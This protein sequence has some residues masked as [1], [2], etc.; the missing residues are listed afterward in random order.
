MPDGTNAPTGRSR[1]IRVVVVD[2]SA[3]LRRVV[4]MCLT[5]EPGIEVVGEAGTGL[6]A[7]EL[8][9]RLQPDIVLL[10]LEMPEMDGLTALPQLRQCSPATRIAVLSAFPDPFTLADALEQGADTYLDKSTALA[11]LPAHILALMAHLED[12]SDDPSDS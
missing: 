10:D 6:E 8:A 2:D 1:P 12:G 9:T 4:R 11:D 5:M 3:D 7:I